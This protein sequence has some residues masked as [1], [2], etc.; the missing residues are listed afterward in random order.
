MKS[1]LSEI[2]IQ[3]KKVAFKLYHCFSYLTALKLTELSKVANIRSD[4]LFKIINDII[5][6]VTFLRNTKCQNQ[7]QL[8]AFILQK[9]LTKLSH[10]I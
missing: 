1:N 6:N 3:E 10:L 2:N 7:H 5:K 8:Q 9:H 4:E